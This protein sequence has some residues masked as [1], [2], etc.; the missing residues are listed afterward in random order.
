MHATKHRRARWP[1]DDL[2]YNTHLPFA[3]QRG[4]GY[5]SHCSFWG[6]YSPSP[7]GHRVIRGMYLTIY[8]ERPRH[9]DSSTDYYRVCLLPLDASQNL[10]HILRKLWTASPIHICRSEFSCFET[11]PVSFMQ[12]HPGLDPRFPPSPVA[13]AVSSLTVSH[14]VVQA[15][16]N[17]SK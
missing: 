9:H 13:S 6:M 16:G 14:R 17:V 10:L 4:R 3:P 5:V 12:G 2:P 8:A 1:W 7:S 11:K 15:V